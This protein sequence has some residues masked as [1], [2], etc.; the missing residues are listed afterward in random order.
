MLLLLWD[1][2]GRLA[3]HVDKHAA[4]NVILCQLSLIQTLISFFLRL[5]YLITPG[6]LY[7]SVLTLRSL[8]V[9]RGEANGCDVGSSYYERIKI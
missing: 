9:I 6:V 5:L 3:C 7:S 4:V 1:P 8:R 2:N